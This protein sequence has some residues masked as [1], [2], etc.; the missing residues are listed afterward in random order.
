MRIRIILPLLLLIFATGCGAAEKNSANLESDDKAVEASSEGSSGY[1][2]LLVKMYYVI[3]EDI[4]MD[5]SDL[6][7]AYVYVYNDVCTDNGTEKKYTFF[8]VVKDNKVIETVNTY[9]Y[10]DRLTGI[11]DMD[12]N[13]DEKND[14]AIIGESGSEIKV[15]LYE[16]TSDFHFDVYSG[17]DDVADAIRESLHPDFGLEELTD[18]LVKKR[19]EY[20]ANMAEETTYSDFK[21]AYIDWIRILRD[22]ELDEY[23]TWIEKYYLYD[24]DKDEIPELFVQYGSTAVNTRVQ[25]YTYSDGKIR[26]IDGNSISNEGLY[27]YPSGNGIML[28]YS[29][30]GHDEYTL[31]SLNNNE[32]SS[33]RLYVTDI[34]SEDYKF[35]EPKEVVPDTFV[36]KSFWIM[37]MDLIE[38][39]EEAIA[40]MAKEYND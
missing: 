24:I 31:L 7:D 33:E 12:F 4:Y 26:H 30:M 25:V 6:E 23:G 38:H 27:A 19:L 3:H 29:H 37:D 35:K 8:D 5:A 28:M 34:E 36:I 18:I 14:I 39:Y 32:F 1:K 40:E 13:I 9:S 21:S 17:W 16:S 22:C 11:T 15:L 20:A 10:L 2:N